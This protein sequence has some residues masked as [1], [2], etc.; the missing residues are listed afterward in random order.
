MG[1]TRQCIHEEIP[2]D[3]RQHKCV[4]PEHQAPKYW[5]IKLLAPGIK[6]THECPGCG[7]LTIVISPIKHL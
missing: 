7:Y 6:S 4:H 3:N 1:T 2:A 5:P